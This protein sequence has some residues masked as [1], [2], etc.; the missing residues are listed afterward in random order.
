MTLVH[1]EHYNY[2]GITSGYEFCIR[3]NSPY[4]KRAT[5]PVKMDCLLELI[6]DRLKPVS[7]DRKIRKCV[8]ILRWIKKIK[9]FQCRQGFSLQV[10]SKKLY[11]AVNRLFIVIYLSKWKKNDQLIIIVIVLFT[12]GT[13]KYFECDAPAP[14]TQAWYVALQTSWSV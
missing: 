6:G 12:S 11:S 8:M 13:G 2:Y 7:I 5:G 9:V 10:S 14:P 4:C 3:Y 1:T